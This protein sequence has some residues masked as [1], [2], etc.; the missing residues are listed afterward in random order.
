MGQQEG[1]RHHG[2]ERNPVSWY[3]YL[4]MLFMVVLVVAFILI[5]CTGWDPA[6]TWHSLRRGGAHHGGY[7]Q[8]QAR[9]SRLSP[10][11]IRDPPSYR[12]PLNRDSFSSYR[13]NDQRHLRQRLNA[14]DD[15][16]GGPRGPAH[17]DDMSYNRRA[18]L[19]KSSVFSN[20]SDSRYW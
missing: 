4:F 16:A 13:G 9:R 3:T 19:N 6:E 11:G 14:T 20:Q 5:N 8:S 2:R 10:G 1:D 12:K 7:Q 17:L 18:D 15:R